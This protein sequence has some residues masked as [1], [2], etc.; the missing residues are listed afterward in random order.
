M[1]LIGSANGATIKNVG[2]VDS[3]LCGYQYVGGIC[4]YDNSNTTIT[5]CYNT[6]AVSGSGIYMSYVGGICGYGSYINTNI[7]NC[8]NVGTVS[9]S[10]YVGGICGSYGAQ[11][12]CHNAG[13]VSGLYAYVG[14]ICGNYGTQTN[15]HNTGTVSGSDKYIGGICGS[16]GTQTN[17]Y[18]TGAV[19]GYSY[20][21][22]I[23]GD[24]G[25]QEC[26]YNIGTV[27]ATS[28]RNPQVG[29]ICGDRGTQTNC[30]Y[31]ADCGSK[32][33]LGVSAT[34][35]EF[36]S[37]EITYLLNCS[38]S[39]NNNEWRQN[40]DDGDN[41][42]AYPVLDKNHKIVYTTQP[43]TTNFSNDNNNA[44]KDHSANDIG[45]CSD[46]GKYITAAPLV[47]G[48]YQ[49]GNA[50][51]LYWF[52]NLVNNGETSANAVL[53]K[54][55][56]VNTDVLNESGELNG[57]PTYSWTPI[58]T[59][60]KPF[61]G[62]FNGNA[63]TISGLYFNNTTD[64]DYPV[65]GNNVGL[66]GFAKGATI[67]DVG[68]IKSYLCGYKNVGGI[69]GNGSISNTD[70]TNCYNT[71][72]VLGYY[73]V[74]GICGYNGNITNCYNTGTV[75]GS[76]NCVGGIC[77]YG[78]NINTD[79]TNCHN[80][81][82]VS[83]STH[84]GGICG[85]GNDSY[86]K[87]TNCHNTG[88]VSGSQFVGGI[89]G[90]GGTQTNCYN[91]G[92]ASG[93]YVGGICGETGIQI[94]CYNTG[95]VSG[96]SN[97]G[98][99]CGYNG[100]QENCYYLEGCGSQN[101]R[102][103]SATAVEFAS[104]YIAYCL[105]GSLNGTTWRQT[106]FA[107]ASPVLDASHNAVTGYID[108]KNDVITVYGDL[109]L[110]TNY[111][112]A[113]GKT[114][115]VP[116]NATVTTTGTAVITNN[117]TLRANGTLSG[118][119]LTGNG[120]FVT[121]LISLCSIS[122]LN[123]SYVYKSTAYT[124]EDGL[125]NVTVS[126]EILG[127]TFIL[128]ASYDGPL[129]TN[130]RNIGT[131]SIKWVNSDDE[132][133]V[134]IDEFEIAP[135][136]LTVTNLIASDKVYDGNNK[137]S[138]QYS[139]NE[140]DGDAITITYTAF[141][142]KKNAGKDKIVSYNFEK[143]GDDAANYA[144][145]NKSGETTANIAKRE[146]EFSSITAAGKEYD[147]NT[148]TTVTIVASNIVDGDVVEFG[149]AANF[150]DKNAGNNKDVNFE[151][152]KSGADAD[153]YK[154][155]TTTGTAKANITPVASEVVVT[156]VLANNT[157][158]YNRTEQTLAANA[159]V[160]CNN[161]LYDLNSSYAEV[162]D[163]AHEVKGTKVGEYAFGW[164]ND[165]FTN[166]D[167]NFANVRFDVTDG[168]LTIVPCTNHHFDD[169]GQCTICGEYIAPE[170]IDGVYQIASAANLYWFADWV[171]KGNLEANAVLTADIVVN[172]QVL[173]ADGSLNG[174]G[175]NF[176][177]WTPIGFYDEEENIEY[178]FSG[179]FD[180]DNHT[181]S[182][183]YLTDYEYYVGLFGI[184]EEA[185]IKNVGIVDSY[186][187]GEAEIGGI[188]GYA[189]SNSTITNCYNIA[190]I[191]CG[192]EDAGGI[193]GWIEEG[194]TITNCYNTGIISSEYNAGGICG[195]LDNSSEIT[196]CYNIATINCGEDYAGGICGYTYHGSITNCHNTGAV[197][198]GDAF[199]GGICSCAYYGSITNCY[200]T[201]TIN[202]GEAYAGGIC[203]Y[204]EES[205]LTNNFYLAGCATVGGGENA[206]V[207]NGI[208]VDADEEPLADAEGVTAATA[209]EFAGG[210]IAYL[211]NNSEQGSGVWYQTLFA[212]EAPVLDA[213]H[214]RPTGY[215]TEEGSVITVTGNVVVAS[216]YEVA[217]DK[218]LSI[219]AGASLTTTGSAVVTNNGTIVV[220]G[221]L[222]GNN[223]EGNGTF[224]YGGHIEEA[225]FAIGETNFVYKGSAYTVDDGI[226]FT[227]SRT[228]CGKEFTY[229]DAYTVSYADNINAGQATIS[230]TNNNDAE[231][232]VSRQFT[233]SP[234]ADE[235]VVTVSLADKTLV[236]N[237]A[238]QTYSATEARSVEADN[239]LYNLEW[240]SES[241]NAASVSGTNVDEYAFGWTAE[242]FENTSGNFS[243]V[244]FNVTDGKLIIAPKT[245]VV[246][247]IT[248]N[249]NEV[250][251]NTEEQSVNGY[252][253]SISDELGIY[254]EDDFNFSGSAVAAGTTVGT[255]PMELSTDNFSNT[256]ANYADV[257]FEIVDGALT[258]TKA[259]EAP[260]KPE[261]TI[262]T[263]Y[264]V[265]QLVALPDDWKWA[266]EQQALEEGDNTATANYAGADKGNYEVESTEVNIKRLP[267]PHDQGDDVLYKLEPT[268]THKGYTGNLCCK[269]CGVIREKGDSI[270]ALGHAYD[271]VVV[272]V[273]CT[274]DGYKELTCTR[275]NHVEQIDVV[276]ATGHTDSV[277][278]EHIVA[279]TCTVAGSQDSVVY[280]SVC[281]EELSRKTVEIKATGHTAGKAVAEN[282]K[283]ATCTEAGS[284]D[285][286]VYCS[287]C[288]TEISRKTVEIKATGH[289]AGK[290]V[291]E[292]L[293]AATCTEAG[294][295]DSVVYCSVC[296]EELSRKTVEIEATGHTAA[297]AVA[298]NLKAAT[299]TEAGSVDSV[300]YCSVCK[301]ELSRK[302]VEI[303]ATGHTAAAAVAE[304]LK[305]A[306]CT[307]AG[308][309]DSVVYCS[310]CNTEISRKTVEI[311]ATG[312]TA[313]EAVAENLK[314]ATCTEAGSVDSVVYCSVC[315]AEISRKTVEIPATG[316]VAGEAVIENVVAATYTA[317]GSYDSVVYC[318]VCK[319]ELS[320][321]TIEVPQLVKPSE[322]EVVEVVVSQVNYTVGDSLNL[323]GGKLIFATSD[324]TTAE[325]VITP[326]MVSGFN[327]D[328]VGVQTVTV[329]FEIDGVPYT[330]TFDVTV[331]DVAKPI[332]AEVIISQV[333]YT[334]G[335]SLKLDGGKIVVATSD[336]T[337]AEVVITP[338]MVSGFNPDSVG[339]QT[340]TV[341]FEI[342]GVPY[343]TTFEV[344]VKEAEV[345]EIVAKSI[346]VGAPTKV[347][348]KKGEQLDVA[349]GKLTVTYSDNTTAEVELK[350]DMVSGFDAD[351]IGEQKLTV[352]YTVDGVTLTATFS[353]TVTKDDNTA[354]D[355]EAAEIN[356]FAYGNTIVVENATDDIYVYN[357]MGALVDHVNAEAD[358]TEIIVNGNEGIYI[359][360]TG[361]TVKRVMVK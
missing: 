71:G 13:T 60:S 156:I 43:C 111:E 319:E 87:I 166:Q 321:V 196:N 157:V 203:G 26:C 189:K 124:L 276:P 100:T 206:V 339:V 146:L 236:Y 194:S 6:G 113:A 178:A 294:S 92:A 5:N 139:T 300:V 277:A 204:M 67:T 342:D 249:S 237:G 63:H 208:G 329:S 57:T 102:G 65:G 238:E 22:G 260:N 344:E 210:H 251:Y 218:T 160:S 155:K 38:T 136:P 53:T 352:S 55:I 232:V 129:Y 52:A 170:E 257:Q 310:V 235:V 99:I 335:D 282:V 201:G 351:K 242:M 274:T 292:N 316:H 81:G 233:I 308:S 84:V 98:G 289:T 161:T 360:K 138:L 357:A 199:V 89:C 9:G 340:V 17:C 223:L 309:V 56:T 169:F 70:I 297:A 355:E 179:T 125:T 46:C 250:V 213:E 348:Y 42:D 80:T 267:C 295:V 190:T 49:I 59:S 270:P 361:N 315:N 271:T 36:K 252:T 332:D 133:D 207:Q 10:A 143:S 326:E 159:Q 95:T 104:G 296:K 320:R 109:V 75:S 220:Y 96:Y 137:T 205:T 29:G 239:E 122:N 147:G 41:T 4:G 228:I 299:C 246:V 323:D 290:A 181:I 105:N 185:T 356:I 174:D 350:A 108:E 222:A 78:S 247:T 188:C 66:I 264:I 15:C 19:T 44:H 234:V 317:A 311:P 255:Y 221:T 172:S 148:A 241:G 198:C 130:N 47:D 142:D 162:G 69:C 7:T 225:D 50:A 333:N 278:Y 346:A 318:T 347:T 312:H 209:S 301:E 334:V 45:H 150:A 101:S 171:N 215:I 27:T 86:T 164:S 115:L 126:T 30:Y 167:N 263:Q 153:N 338:E 254:S 306:T 288:N 79:I 307:E 144:F 354:I 269:L 337:T 123:E 219:P 134:L 195:Y 141:F 261:A 165:S 183:L 305:A 283:E 287:V 61:V 324:S 48:Y 291:A 281:K 253:V 118:N 182:G 180:G 275:C 117:G 76:T 229:G 97:V 24:F 256:N 1:G 248:E 51:Q 58:G 23:C 293:K 258:I 31:L 149:T 244:T 33:T 343:T 314:A 140:F 93:Y 127:K 191:T 131:A 313:G 32:N 114:L 103:V 28:S 151:F 12:N 262:E 64:N 265:T 353:V 18:N 112:I 119:N 184:V 37:G 54:D 175:S 168:K 197:T 20:I 243:N 226:E 202:C 3:Y 245:G 193:C 107:D 177:T 34:A 25:V 173:A 145:T 187:S 284:V 266:D 106:L 135:A 304:N 62:T 341:S 272:A 268:C 302:T 286:V 128:D 212:D 227:V 200:N 14:G 154:F 152:T 358:R 68:V 94:N 230:L 2:V 273:T 259:P 298:E 176:R 349:G 88:T 72:T 303:E 325:V 73:A 163:I 77:G 39:G 120:T 90:Y 116:A 214:N 217:N 85:S 35:D 345:I 322:A 83:G 110:T 330:T 285:S 280:C 359:V 192:E 216:D 327:P 16:D 91:T 211:L 121:E 132:S 231:N 82:T 336:S 74:G 331:K 21:G 186:F 40:L 328:S 224:I 240:I 158:I 279:A 11:T 8:H